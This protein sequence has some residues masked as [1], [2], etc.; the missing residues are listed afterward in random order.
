[1]SKPDGSGPK[2]RALSDREVAEY[3]RAHPDFLLRHSDLIETLV[4]PERRVEG[5]AGGVV[6][7]LQRFMLERMREELRE[8]RGTQGQLI[9]AGRANMAAQSRVHEAVLALLTA[10]SF[11]RLIETVT[12]DLSILLDLDVATL[13]VERREASEEDQSGEAGISVRGLHRLDPGEIER[14]MQSAR[15]IQLMTSV[16]G[17][18]V[19]FG[20]MAGLVRSQAFIRLQISTATPPALL[21]LGARDPEAFHPGQATELLDFLGRSLELTLRAWL[22]LPE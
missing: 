20:P 16:Q 6:L 21:A 8:V 5:A 18:P 11:E 10:P 1:M 9:S 3:L 19:I 17:D 22:D 4:P 14:A 15:R 7:D 2:E 12:D 13:C